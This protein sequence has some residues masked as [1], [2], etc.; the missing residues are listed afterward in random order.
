MKNDDFRDPFGRAPV[1]VLVIFIKFQG[2]NYSGWLFG[3][4]DLAGPL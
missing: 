1:M 3:Q 4:V 2:S